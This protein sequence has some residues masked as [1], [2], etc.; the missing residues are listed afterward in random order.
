MPEN[1]IHSNLNAYAVLTVL[2][3]HHNLRI[4]QHKQK[5]YSDN[6]SGKAYKQDTHTVKGFTNKVF[7]HVETTEGLQF[8]QLDR[9][10]SS[11]K[12]SEGTESSSA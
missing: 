9:R 2:C 7:E 11:V 12:N 5:N 4:L 1:S 8:A 3:R 6:H 10:F